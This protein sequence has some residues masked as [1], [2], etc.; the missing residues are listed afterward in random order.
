M[1]DSGFGP[2]FLARHPGL[3]PAG[4]EITSVADENYNCVAWALGRTDVWYQPGG[5]KGTTWPDGVPSDFSVAAY[6]A[7][8]KS[9]GFEAT[10][11]TD[12]NERVERLA[13]YGLDGDFCH[14]AR[15]TSSG[16]TSKCG[17]LQDITHASLAALEDGVYGRSEVI[18][19]REVSN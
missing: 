6:V 1:P 11:T 14:V 9:F 8:F 12:Y 2:T 17:E 15:Q 3:E 7:F 18:L 4:F 5:L 19:E 10:K 16:W 13:L